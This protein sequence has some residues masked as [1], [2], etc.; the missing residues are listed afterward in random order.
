MTGFES[1]VLRFRKKKR[2]ERAEA[3]QEEHRLVLDDVGQVPK[4][5]DVI[6]L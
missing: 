1:F 3:R 2:E 6:F 5:L 4:P